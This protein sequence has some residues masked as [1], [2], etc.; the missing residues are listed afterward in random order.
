VLND[1][2]GAQQVLD[3][4]VEGGDTLTWKCKLTKPVPM[5]LT[6]TA[7]V[8][9]EQNLQ[10]KLVGTIMGKSVMDC[11]VLGKS[12]QG[13][14]A[15]AAKAESEKFALTDGEKKGFFAKIFG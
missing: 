12:V 8:D 13:D 7:Q 10:G 5:T 3:G 11:G 2:H 9:K 14:K 1:E 6:Y 15:D 4:K